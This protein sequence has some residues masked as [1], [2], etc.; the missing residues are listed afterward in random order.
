MTNRD[1]AVS[2]GIEPLFARHTR[3]W[4][5]MW[6]GTQA[7]A[8]LVAAYVAVHRVGGLTAFRALGVWPS[9]LALTALAIGWH[10][11]GVFAYRQLLRRSW[12]VLCY[13]G[14]AWIQI[15][16]IAI[17][18]RPFGLLVIGA[19][20]QAFIF[21][22]FR[23]AAAVLGALVISTAIG[24]AA[25]QHYRMVGEAITGVVATLATGAMAGTVILYIHRAN[26]DAAI[27][28]QLLHRLADAQ[29]DLTDRA[30]EAGVLQ[31][32]ARFSRDL[33]DTLAQGFTSVIRQLEAMELMLASQPAP[34]GDE[35]YRT[36]ALRLQPHLHHAQS[37]SRANLD[38]IRRLVWNLRPFELQGT[39]LVEAV[40]RVT[41]QWSEVHDVRTTFSA[42]ALP[43]LHPDADVVILRATQEALS[44]VARHAK[45]THV[46]ITIHC[47][48]ALVMLTIEDNGTGMTSV[49]EP[50][51]EG[52]GV[53][54]MR[55]RVR[56][57]QG[58]VL[59][60]S[61]A[62]EG[63]SVTVAIPLAAIAIA[64]IPVNDGS[65]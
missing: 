50:G 53:S 24:T 30:Q 33:H 63:T 10:L 11:L 15:V 34:S 4:M 35:T 59:I 46:A 20:L 22:P 16:W 52:V 28:T 9:L 17:L 36:L 29:R 49:P 47:I 27:R 58:K 56:Q 7:T 26:R 48:D 13:V 43:P 18:M 38:D 39:S 65:A 23:I 55:D 12:V 8:L 37:V 41:A 31:E 3:L 21:L 2:T 6:T 61:R 42:D 40:E 64:T 51:R 44:N 5:R 1:D 45:A 25:E 32:R 62:G 57:F 60:E 14:L 19:V 54:G